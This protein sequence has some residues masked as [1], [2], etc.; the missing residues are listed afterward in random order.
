M[1]PKLK[2]MSSCKLEMASVDGTEGLGHTSLDGTVLVS[3]F[4]FDSKLILHFEQ[5][6]STLMSRMKYHQHQFRFYLANFPKMSQ[7]MLKVVS[8]WKKN[9]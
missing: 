1:A 7:V 2:P 5:I 4:E 8:K 3:I 6:N 9:Y